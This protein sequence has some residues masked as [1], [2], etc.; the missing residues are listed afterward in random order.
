MTTG[1]ES[2]V[3]LLAGASGLKT[4]FDTTAAGILLQMF[5]LLR[6]LFRSDCRRIAE[7][8]SSVV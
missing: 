7:R 2:I 5:Q 6:R 4:T 8:L 1:D 3:P